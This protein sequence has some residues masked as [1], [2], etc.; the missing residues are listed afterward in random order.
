MA[1][2]CRAFR[3]VLYPTAGR[4]CLL[5]LACWTKCSSALAP[6]PLH[7]TAPKPLF[8]E[9]TDKLA[10]LDILSSSLGI[11]KGAMLLSAWAMFYRCWTCSWDLQKV[12]SMHQQCSVCVPHKMDEGWWCTDLLMIDWPILPAWCG[13]VLRHPPPPAHQQVYAI[14]GD[15][16]VHCTS[17]DLRI[18]RYF[19]IQQYSVRRTLFIIP[20]DPLLEF[21]RMRYDLCYKYLA[22][23]DDGILFRPVVL[24]CTAVVPSELACSHGVRSYN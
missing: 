9:F 18:R 1:V 22:A 3:I 20:I 23:T 4:C 11:T 8:G 21:N 7:A 14:A 15:N 13:I 6:G 17:L 24:W 2:F 12:E 10:P 16:D 5:R 19:C